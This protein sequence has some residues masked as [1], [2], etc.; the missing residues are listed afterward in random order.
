MIEPTI[1]R[2]LYY[3]ASQDDLDDMEALSDQPFDATIIH[4]NSSGTL[5][6]KVWDHTGNEFT[7][8]DVYLVQ[9]EEEG[10]VTAPFAYWM[11]YQNKVAEKDKQTI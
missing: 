9:A 6:L 8:T 1:G 11:P 4:V 3:S 2:K 7:E 10:K 5:N